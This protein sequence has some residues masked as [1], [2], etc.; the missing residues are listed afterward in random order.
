MKT[1]SKQTNSSGTLKKRNERG[2][3]FLSEQGSVAASSLGIF[4]E[5]EEEVKER[6]NLA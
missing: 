4:A 3:F 5:S 6:S 2:K 1:G